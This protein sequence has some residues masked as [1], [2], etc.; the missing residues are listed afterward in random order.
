MKIEDKTQGLKGGRDPAC[1]RHRQRGGFP[2]VGSSPEQE[3][4]CP[5]QAPDCTL[6]VTFVPGVTQPISGYLD[7]ETTVNNDTGGNGFI[8]IMEIISSVSFF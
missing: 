1:P 4:S 2:K 5:Q 3:P 7:K 6:T 8:V